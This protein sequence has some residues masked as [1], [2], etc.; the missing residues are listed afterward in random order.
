[1]ICDVRLIG[2]TQGQ[3]GESW[4]DYFGRRL[5]NWYGDEVAGLVSQC[6]ME[7]GSDQFPPLRVSVADCSCR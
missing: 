6:L 2:V 1:M 7:T 5:G 4:C 3:L